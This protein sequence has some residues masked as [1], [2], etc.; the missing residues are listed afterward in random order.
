MARPSGTAAAATAAAPSAGPGFAL[1]AACRR[2]NA[3]SSASSTMTPS[4]LKVMPGWLRTSPLLSS[5][6]IAAMTYSVVPIRPSA[7]S[8]PLVTARPIRPPIPSREYVS[9]MPTPG[10]LFGA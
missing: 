9:P 3:R 10:R 1:A 5:T 6:E 7:S 2:R 8:A 4:A